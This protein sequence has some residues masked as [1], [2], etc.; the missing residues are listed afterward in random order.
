MLL[1]DN[2]MKYKEKHR[3]EEGVVGAE[4]ERWRTWY[5]VGRVEESLRHMTNGQLDS[6]SLTSE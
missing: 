2:D 6:S 4:R 3:V 1:T 5:E